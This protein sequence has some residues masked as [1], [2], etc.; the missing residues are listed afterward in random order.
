MLKLDCAI[1]SYAWGKRGTN[2]CVARFKESQ[3]EEF[4][5]DENKSYAELW[6]GTHSNG[7]SII[8][9]TKAKLNDYIGGDLPFLF[10]ILSVNQALSIQAHP[11]K[12]LARI[13]HSNDPKNYPDSNHKPEMLIALT[14]FQALCGFRPSDEIK[15]N[16]EKIPE[17]V[18]LCDG[19]FIGDEESLK[20][21]FSSMM[22]RD[23]LFIREIFERFLQNYKT[24]SIDSKL[25]E[26]FDRLHAEYPFD[27][28]CFSI[29]LLNYFE[30]E[31]NEAV[32]LQANVPH[33]YLYGD[34]VECMA[35]SDNVVRAGL[36]PKYKDVK[37]LVEMLDYKMSKASLVDA[38]RQND[39]I[40][41]YKPMVDE[42]SVQRIEIAEGGREK[43]VISRS[44]DK[45]SILIVIKVNNVSFD[46]EALKNG[47]VYLIDRNIKI[48]INAHDSTSL[49]LAYRAYVNND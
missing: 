49:L 23:E 28:G 6:M 37:T 14:K 29:F 44:M 20:K 8:S 47:L 42:F 32:Y 39:F 45:Y 31:P 41:E 43:V 26:L 12:Q 5:I 34:G 1:Q 3:N 27:I 9:E 25:V 18:K 21:C 35:C 13:L 4:K 2:S 24:Y 48:E 40:H 36:T 16:F 17:L 33:A 11:N 19:M 46:G 30:L 22:N 10:K 15:M 38:V 7:P